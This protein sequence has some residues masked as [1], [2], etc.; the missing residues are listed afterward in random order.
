[1][2]TAAQRPVC[3]DF[4]STPFPATVVGVQ[5]GPRAV[6]EPRIWPKW[7]SGRGAGLWMSPKIGREKVDSNRFQSCG[8]VKMRA[9]ARDDRSKPP[10]RGAGA[11]FPQDL[12]S[13]EGGPAVPGEPNGGA[14]GEF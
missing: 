11:G 14:K 8:G 9:G 6:V 10:R 4:E 3:R 2:G 1:M 7:S 5:E 12:K 13:N